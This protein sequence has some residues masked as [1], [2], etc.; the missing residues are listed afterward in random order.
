MELPP[1]TNARLIVIA[2]DSPTQA[3][4]LKYFLEKCGYDV[5]VAGNGKEALRLTSLY[6]PSLV[7]S[8]IIMPEMGG[9]E[10][11]REIKAGESTK[12]IPVILLTALSS[13]EDVLESLIFSADSF[14]CKPFNENFLISHIERTLEGKKLH[15][16][17]HADIDLDVIVAGEP[18]SIRLNPAKM[19]TLL[20]STYDAAVNK[21]IELNR[22][23]EELRALNDHLE[24]LVRERTVALNNEIAEQVRV[25][26]ELRKT[27]LEREKLIG[28]LQYALD[29]IKT[30]QG[31]IPICANCKKVRDD[32]GY[33]SQV[34][35]YIG[36]HTEATFSHGVCPPC[37]KKLYGDLY[38]RAMKKSLDTELLKE[39]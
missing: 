34:E 2:E 9:Y 11:C 32:Q 4:R 20:I 17:H 19:L 15:L 26:K 36:K 18:R 13:S 6:K 7:I 28:E 29:N 25:S 5:I 21:N 38:D 24:E 14:I 3:E 33:W 23:Q 27:T 30:L 8:D 12:D 37:G 10:L 39:E 35:E 22:S 31:L 16:D 1:N